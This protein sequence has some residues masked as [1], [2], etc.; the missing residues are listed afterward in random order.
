V[1]EA[2]GVWVSLGV[3][4]LLYAAVGTA[5]VLVLRAMARRWRTAELDESEGPYAPR[6][7]LQELSEEPT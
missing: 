2:S 6:P 3:V 4:L 7:G 1:T 5:T